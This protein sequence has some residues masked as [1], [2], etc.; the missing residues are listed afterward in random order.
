MPKKSNLDSIEHRVVVIEPSSRKVLMCEANG[1]PRLLRVLISPKTRP[2]RQLCTELK[3][4]WGIAVLILDDLGTSTPTCVTAELLSSQGASAFLR[5]NATEIPNGE[6]SDEEQLYLLKVLAD[7]GTGPFSHIA[8]IDEAIA[9]IG[10]TTGLSPC[11]KEDV[12]QYNAGATS[13]LVRFPVNSGSSYWL[14]ATGVR[15]A[16]ERRLTHLLSDIA[17][18]CLPRFLNAKPEWNAWLT[19]STGRSLAAMPTEPKEVLRLLGAAVET[20]AKL[21]AKTAGKETELLEAG[22]F[23]QRLSVMCNQAHLLFDH[24]T[25]G[26]ALQISTKAP[27]LSP[28]RL[29]EVRR[30]FEDTCTWIE[31]QAIPTTIVHND[32]N[33]GNLAFTEN[34]C[35]L[36]DWAEGYVGH[37]LVTL[38]HLLLLNPIDDTSTRASVDRALKDR[39]SLAMREVCDPSLL[40]A[41]FRLMPLVAAASALYGRGDWLQSDIPHSRARHAYSRM[42]ARYMDRAVTELSLEEAPCQ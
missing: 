1:T 7:Q 38:Q 3:R 33:L 22:A 11:A 30:I 27:R 39:Y 26:M 37:P 9:W 24:V 28:R 13:T 12:E 36:L 21:Q 41:A 17:P 42:L 2:A 20:L 23:D 25:E 10:E 18:D 29:S 31:A 8:W 34:R 6:L 14:K 40:E 19:M 4:L 35:H 32:M 16:H 15:H 5:V